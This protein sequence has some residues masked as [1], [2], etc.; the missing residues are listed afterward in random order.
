[1]QVRKQQL[2]LD[3]EQQTSSKLGKEYIKVV[4][5][6]PA[7]LINLY[8]EYIMRNAQ[9][10]EA[11]AIIKIA[12]RDISNLSYADDNHPYGRKQ[13]GTKEPLEE[14]EKGGLKLNIQNTKIMASSFITSWQIDG[15]TMETVT[16]F[17][18]LSSKITADGDCSHEIKRQLL[19]G[20][21]AMTNLDNILKSRAITL[22]MKVCPVKAMFFPVVMYGC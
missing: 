7:Y 14:S 15:E 1:M 10:G 13:R 16:D 21:K 12:G 5:C 4:Y 18:F 3:M 19:L 17:V 2:E 9:L 6:H 22:P 8:A 20:K 11:Q